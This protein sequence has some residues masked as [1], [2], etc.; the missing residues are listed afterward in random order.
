MSRR[1]ILVLITWLLA[2][3]LAFGGCEGDQGLEGDTG[4]TG[5]QGPPGE[6]IP[7]IFSTLELYEKLGTKYLRATVGIYGTPDLPLVTISGIDIPRNDDAIL[8]EGK[9]EYFREFPRDMISDTANLSVTWTK[10]TGLTALADAAITIPGLFGIIAPDTS[11]PVLITNSDS[12]DIIWSQSDS[13][14]MY[15]ARFS[16]EYEYIDT[17]GVD[18]LFTLL[19]DTFVTDTSLKIDSATIFPG[20]V[21][22]TIENLTADFS[23]YASIG[24]LHPDSAWNISG[25]ATGYFV[26]YSR[27]GVLSFE[28]YMPFKSRKASD[29]DRSGDDKHEV[30]RKLET[31]AGY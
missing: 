19:V 3:I 23:L 20:D 10:T 8:T 16:M 26:S 22:G 27:G 29:F 24:P 9:L 7:N 17:A 31:K 30:Y 5:L 1:Y 28:Y 11:G 25:D 14:E 4:L 18:G 6:P 2:I 15:W 21:A 13:A 12:I